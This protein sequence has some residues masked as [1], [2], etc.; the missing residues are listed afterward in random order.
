MILRAAILC[1]FA[2]LAACA[3]AIPGYTPPPF[4]ESKLV[5]PMRAG[6]MD[7][8]GVYHMSNQEKA[9]TQ[10]CRVTVEP[11]SY[12]LASACSRAE[13]ADMPAEIPSANTS[14]IAVFISTPR[15]GDAWRLPVGSRQLPVQ[16]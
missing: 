13:T 6:D 5:K 14:A 15:G 1:T 10:P 16:L 12:F 7:A 3:A 9:T 11:L 4:K 2:L 8:D